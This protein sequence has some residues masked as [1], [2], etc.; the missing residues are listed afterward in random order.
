M[1]LESTI[2]VMRVLSILVRHMAPDEVEAASDEL[3]R[4]ADAEADPTES[5]FLREAAEGLHKLAADERSRPA[6]HDRRGRG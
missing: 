1:S 2:A 5:E 3:S 6:P 4:A